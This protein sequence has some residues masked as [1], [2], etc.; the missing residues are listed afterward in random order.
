MSVEIDLNSIDIEHNNYE[1]D[2]GSIKLNIGD[3]VEDI[4]LDNTISTLPGAE[5]LMNVKKR[6]N[7]N[8][9]LSPDDLDNLE[10]DLNNLV[11]NNKTINSDNDKTIKIDTINQSEYNKKDGHN[12]KIEEPTHKSTIFGSTFFSGKKE[13]KNETWD[14][15][16]QF[17][18]VPIDP[19]TNIPKHPEIS[20]EELLKEKFKYLKKLE[21]LEKRGIEI[22]RKYN[23]DSSLLEMQGEYETI[24]SEREKQNSVKFQRRMMMAAITGLEFMNNRF[25]PFDFKLDGWSE[26]VNENINDYDDI[27]GE[28]HEKYQSKAKMAPEL[29]LLFQLGGSAIM[30]HMTNTMFKSSVP[31]MDDIMRQNPELMEQFTRA[32]VN[33]VGNSNPGFGNF[34]NGMMNNKTKVLDS[35]NQNQPFIIMDHHL[36][37]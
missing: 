9:E 18:D 17:N 1:N 20:K 5:L 19:E 21:E 29:K 37:Q 14:G 13:E 12:E 33:Q 36:L 6:R 28:L 27:F 7:S 16:K 8:M 2:N 3:D 24:K 11:N 23:M 22:S 26:Q 31:G 25:D 35:V 34:M 30:L 4:T 32:A 10:S 15:Y